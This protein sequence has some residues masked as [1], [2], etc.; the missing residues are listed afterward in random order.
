MLRIRKEQNEALAKASLEGFRDRLATHIKKCWPER[1][2][3]MG[4]TETYQAIQKGFDK[5]DEYGFETEYDVAR[6]IDLMYL[7]SFDFDTDPRYPWA[8]A[9]LNERISGRSKMDKFY[10]QA[11]RHLQALAVQQEKGN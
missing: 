5:S 7:L 8:S 1:A 11:E 10:T 4:Q 3:Q 9:I 2:T 6:Y